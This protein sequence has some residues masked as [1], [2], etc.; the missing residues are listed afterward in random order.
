MAKEGGLGDNLYVGGYDLSGDVGSISSISGGPAALDVT[1]IK[2]KARERIG[3]R[4]DGRMEYL[5]FFNDAAGQAHPVLKVL[6][7]SDV[8]VTYCHTTILGAASAGLVAKQPNYPGSRPA[9]GAFTFSIEELG[10]AFGL[11][12]GRQLTAG[13]RTDTAA[14]N[15]SSIDTTASLAFGAQA[16]LQAFSFTGTD[17][18]V[19]LQ[20]SAD[21]SSWADLTG[22]GF[23]QITGGVPLAQRI[24]TSLG[25]TVRR[26]LRVVTV[27]TGGFS[28]LA[29]AVTVV[30]NEVA[31]VF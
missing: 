21:D 7:S 28:S 4:R 12:W 13:I 29:F 1:P 5:S 23:T 30:K 25:Q 18:T 22:G 3:G 19:K 10:N 14:T 15:G 6:P 31:V 17:V 8:P 11:E 24:A 2:F 9:D 20:D 16:Y 27:T 26:Y